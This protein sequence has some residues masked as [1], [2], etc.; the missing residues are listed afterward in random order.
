MSTRWVFDRV[1]ATAYG[2]I[3]A[4]LLLVS[5]G[6]A[7]MVVVWT[8]VWRLQRPSQTQSPGPQRRSGSSGRPG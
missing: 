6:V 7:M 5:G 8:V 3:M 1:G 4:L 2:R